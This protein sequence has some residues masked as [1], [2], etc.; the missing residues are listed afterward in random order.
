MSFITENCVILSTY[1]FIPYTLLDLYIVRTMICNNIPNILLNY[2]NI[3][4]IKSTVKIRNLP[5]N[6]APCN[7]N[8]QQG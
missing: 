8:T 4:L 5:L 6:K 1:A 2:C 3:I 7:T